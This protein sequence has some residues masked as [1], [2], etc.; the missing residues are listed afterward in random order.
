MSAGV[1]DGCNY[2]SCMFTCP[3]CSEPIPCT[4]RASADPLAWLARLAKFGYHHVGA[5]RPGGEQ[6]A[7]TDAKAHL[8]GLQ[9]GHYN[10][11]LADQVLRAVGLPDASE[12]RALLSA[13]VDPQA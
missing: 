2:L 6:H 7:L 10:H 12:N 1:G 8:A 11:L 13:N 9:I 3:A 5:V 4:P